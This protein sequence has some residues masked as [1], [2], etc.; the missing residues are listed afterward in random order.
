MTKNEFYTE[1]L[2]HFASGIPQ[3]DIEQYVVAT[4]NYLWHVFSWELLDK[5]DYLT[6]ECAKRAYDQADKQDAV[7]IAWFE[8]DET[9]QL[10]AEL[11]TAAALD[12]ITE[13]Y[14]AAPDFSWTYMKTHECICGP[15][16]MK[17]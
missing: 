15:Y 8:D 10:T 6:G 2:K 12:R 5:A 13:V 4:G 16:F 17:L 9:K 11:T 3:K 14:I 1:W 7:M